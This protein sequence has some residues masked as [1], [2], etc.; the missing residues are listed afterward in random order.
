MKQVKFTT[1]LLT[2]LMMLSS[3]F[4]SVKPIG[5][6]VEAIE[7]YSSGNK[8]Q[9]YHYGK[10]LI[11]P[12]DKYLN[13]N[14]YHLKVHSCIPR[15]NIFNKYP[16]V[17]KF[18]FFFNK[19]DSKKIADEKFIRATILGQGSTRWY[20]KESFNMTKIETDNGI[21]LEGQMRLTKHDVLTYDYDYSFRNGWTWSGSYNNYQYIK[22]RIRGNEFLAGSTFGVFAKE[23][24]Y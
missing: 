5:F 3:V 9:I 23:C 14:D 21:K 15:D 11:D 17:L 16:L 24:E 20:V 2:F 1:I 7:D 13:T 18:T 8:E 22:L 10:M 12:R 6:Q 4:A 19:E